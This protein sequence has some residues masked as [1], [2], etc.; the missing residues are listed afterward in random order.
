MH[1]PRE[2]LATLPFDVTDDEEVIVEEFE[3]EYYSEDE[4]YDYVEVVDEESSF[5]YVED[6][7]EVD[8]DDDGCYIE[9]V[10]VEDRV[11][12]LPELETI[13]EV[14][15]SDEVEELEAED[16]DLVV[17]GAAGSASTLCQ[18]DDVDDGEQDSDD[19]SDDSDDKSFIDGPSEQ[20]DAYEHAPLEHCDFCPL[21]GIRILSKLKKQCHAHGLPQPRVVFAE[22][23]KQFSFRRRKGTTA[24]AGTTSEVT[25]SGTD[26]GQTLG[27]LAR[28]LSKRFKK[29][30]SKQFSRP[31]HSKQRPRQRQRK[32]N[33][34]Y[35]KDNKPCVAAE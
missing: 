7:I 14:D 26:Q 25:T 21:P 5:F 20:R 16:V 22:L 2:H 6:A 17:V 27:K 35:I 18:D 30:V 1:L 12:F 29:R 19:Y 34:P 32:P 13:S 9:E 10:V 4:E 23:E 8:I 3:Y 31:T 33:R 11:T 28:R 15:E 24:T